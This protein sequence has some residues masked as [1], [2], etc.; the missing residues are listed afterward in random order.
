MNQIVVLDGYP[1][2][3]GDL[4]WDELK[5]LGNVRVYEKTL[6]AD[7]V[8]RIGEASCIFTNKVPIT[9]S[10]IESCPNLRFIGVLATGFN[11]IDT[12]AAKEKGIIVS[13][14]P[15]YSTEAVAQYVFALLL[16][17]CHHVGY[18]SS[19]MLKRSRDGDRDW[20]FWDYPLME[21]A[22]KTMGII[23]FGQIGR[24]TA[25]R[26]QAFG[27]DVV[28]YSRSQTEE[29]RR[30]APYVSLQEL[31][32]K[33]DVISLHVPLFP[34]TEGLINRTSIAE[35]KDGVIVINT[36]RGPIVN[37][38]DMA[39]AL[40]SG[41]VFYYATDVTSI[42]PIPADNP[43]LSARNCIIT[44]HIAWAPKETRR[45]LLGIAAD[46]LKHFLAGNPI[47]VVNR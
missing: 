9:R 4:S 10:V 29:G 41:K 36:A 21:L 2:N 38:S 18:H 25:K 13:N 1:A 44:P 17:V 45:R 30:I 19:E 40:N 11:T 16:E 31:Y 3:P 33:A 34:A 47:N 39:E 5:K 42:E 37:E 23:G 8:A 46:N 7:V 20:C 32:K 27:M 43:L 15:A 24:A 26:A 35:M 12:E 22:G 6:K 28:A 14:I